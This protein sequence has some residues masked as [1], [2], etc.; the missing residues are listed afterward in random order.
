ML[1]FFNSK[2]TSLGCSAI[3]GAFAIAMLFDQNWLLAG[4]CMVAS[5]YCFG[6]Y[7]KANN[8]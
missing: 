6:N 8:Q 4:I 1:D 3:N 7:F 5:G 2:Y